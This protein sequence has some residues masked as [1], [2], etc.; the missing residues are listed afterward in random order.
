V[1]QSRPKEVE[2]CEAFT[3]CAYDRAIANSYARCEKLGTGVGS[4]C[5]VTT[6]GMEILGGVVSGAGDALK[7]LNPF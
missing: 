5:K 6:K 7:R 4:V 2:T 1:A 3:Q